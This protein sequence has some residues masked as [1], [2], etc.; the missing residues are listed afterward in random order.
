[1]PK[2][3]I[4]Y[5]RVHEGVVIYGPK[6]FPGGRIPPGLAEQY[7]EP[8]PEASQ[9]EREA[10]ATGEPR[11]EIAG[12]IVTSDISD[13]GPEQSAGGLL[14]ALLNHAGQSDLQQIHGVG[15]KTAGDIIASR[16]AA[17]PFESFQDAADRVGGLTVS[18]LESA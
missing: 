14:L 11:E 15:K 6:D 4:P 2:N 8:L 16:E 18:M 12:D 10:P 5:P 1:M 13:A 3:Q 9:D 7:V 17:G